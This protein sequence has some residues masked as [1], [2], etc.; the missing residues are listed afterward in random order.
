MFCSN[1]GKEINEKSNFCPNCGYRVDNMTNAYSY[2]SNSTNVI[3]NKNNSGSGYGVLSFFLPLCGLILYLVWRKNR[4]EYAK[5]CIVGT[6]IALGLT[7]LSIL[8]MVSLF[9]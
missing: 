3:T 6:L 9:I 8:S 5:A 2:T 1:C 7:V 4:P